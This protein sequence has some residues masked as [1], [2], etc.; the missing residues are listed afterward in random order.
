MDNIKL[1]VRKGSTVFPFAHIFVCWKG[2]SESLRQ[3]VSLFL[4]WFCPPTCCHQSGR[5]GG[6]VEA[7]FIL[8]PTGNLQTSSKYAKCIVDLQLSVYKSISVCVLNLMK[9][10]T[11]KEMT[12]MQVWV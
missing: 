10:N 7:V 1:V 9:Y 6:E 11:D 5:K 8:V 2:R 4:P 12:N 3:W